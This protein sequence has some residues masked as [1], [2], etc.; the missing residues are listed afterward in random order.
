VRV[1]LHVSE[2]LGSLPESGDDEVVAGPMI[3]DFEDDVSAASG[4]STVVFEH[5][6]A[7]AEEEAE[8]DLVG[9]D[10]GSH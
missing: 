7:V 5:E 3:D 10:G 1:G 2:P 8:S 6:Q 9:S 4:D